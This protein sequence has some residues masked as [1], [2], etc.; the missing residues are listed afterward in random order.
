MNSDIE[1]LTNL[2][3]LLALKHKEPV[4]IV[5][6]N[7]TGEKVWAISLDIQPEFWLDAELTKTE[8]IAWCEKHH[9]LYKVEEAK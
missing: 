2:V 5:E 7:E 3:Y 8:A 4:T 9:L 6:S 1:G